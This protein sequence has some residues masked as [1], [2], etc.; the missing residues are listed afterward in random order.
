M[1]QAEGV[2]VQLPV[3][4]VLLRYHNENGETGGWSVRSILE[5]EMP[6]ASRSWDM[7]REFGLHPKELETTGGFLAGDK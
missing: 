4:K 2:K 3:R 5:V 6:E 1:F 7:G